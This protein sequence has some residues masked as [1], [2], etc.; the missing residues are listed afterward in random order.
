MLIIE[1]KNPYTLASLDEHL[2]FTEQSVAWRV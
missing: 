2:Q 1:W